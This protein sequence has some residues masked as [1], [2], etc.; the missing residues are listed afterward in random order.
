[1]VKSMGLIDMEIFKDIN[2]YEGKYQISNFGNVRSLSRLV[3]RG[4][5]KYHTINEVTLKQSI[6]TAGYLFVIL[7]KNSKGKTS[8]IHQLVAEA[9]LGHVS[10]KGNLTIDHIDNNK[11]N[12]LLSNLQI[13]THRENCSKDKIGYSSKYVGV[14]WNKERRKWKATIRVNKKPKHLG[15]FDCEKKASEAYQRE[16]KKL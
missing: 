9:F 16:L 15:T 6:D 13:I 5:G 4:F 7:Y 10:D 11:R 3:Y 8:R 2:N 12:N 14:H 1:M